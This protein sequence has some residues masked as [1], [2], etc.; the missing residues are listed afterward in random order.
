MPP[1]RVSATDNIEQREGGRQERRPPST[2]YKGS[3]VMISS[4]RLLVRRH[5]GGQDPDLAKR[6]SSEPAKSFPRRRPVFAVCWLNRV[7]GQAEG[8]GPK[9]HGLAGTVS[10]V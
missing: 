7:S 8:L 4:V 5:T 6:D 1:G 10:D 2:Q 3:S 9:A